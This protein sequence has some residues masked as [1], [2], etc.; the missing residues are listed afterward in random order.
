[1]TVSF[2]IPPVS[3]N[4]KPTLSTS[5]S[6]NVG[7]VHLVTSSAFLFEQYICDGGYKEEQK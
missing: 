4:L 1:L 3:L 5:I 2:S 6:K 7:A